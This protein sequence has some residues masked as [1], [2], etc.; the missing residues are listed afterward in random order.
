MFIQKYTNGHSFLYHYNGPSK[1]EEEKSFET[2]YSMIMVFSQQHCVLYKNVEIHLTNV[3][4]Q[5]RNICLIFIH[6]SKRG[7]ICILINLIIDDVDHRII[8]NI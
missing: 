4:H 1:K 7:I 3:K 2:I 8:S 5:V 6:D